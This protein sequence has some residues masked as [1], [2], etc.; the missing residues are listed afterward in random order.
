MKCK[1]CDREAKW[2]IV[3]L[4]P[5]D[6]LFLPLCE[7]HFQELREMEGE[8]N[9]DFELIAN[10]SLEDIV[11][12]S[13]EKWKYMNKR[14]SNLLNLYSKLEEKEAIVKDKLKKEAKS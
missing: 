8:M 5:Y 9:L 11:T 4:P 6:D 10:L 1:E 12:K 13:N 2:L 7:E 3:D 14:Y